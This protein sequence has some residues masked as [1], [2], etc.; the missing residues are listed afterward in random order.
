[1]C[2]GAVDNYDDKPYTQE[3][4]SIYEDLVQIVSGGYYV[5]INGTTW[6]NITLKAKK[7]MVGNRS[8]WQIYGLPNIH[9]EFVVTDIARR[10]TFFIKN[11]DGYGGVLAY[12]DKTSHNIST[13]DEYTIQFKY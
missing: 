9:S 2:L 5:D 1:M 7:N 11:A 13:N 8:W 6:V 4:L 12:A 10:K 3:G